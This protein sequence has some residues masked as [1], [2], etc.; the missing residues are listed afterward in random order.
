MKLIFF[1][2][3]E[4]LTLTKILHLTITQG[5]KI[6]KIDCKNY[7][8]A[9]R[10]DYGLYNRPSTQAIGKIVKRFEETGVTT[11][12]ERHYRFARSAENI[13]VVSGGVVEGLGIRN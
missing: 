1:F 13:A 2:P 8:S 12:I 10:G 3:I 6:I 11:N 4:S 9:L 7:D 5:T